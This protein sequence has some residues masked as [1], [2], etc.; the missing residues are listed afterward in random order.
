MAHLVRKNPDPFARLVTAGVMVWLIGQA[1][2]NIAVVL[3]LLPV[4]GIPLPFMS[5]GGSALLSSLAAVGIVIALN[6][7]GAVS[8]TE[9]FSRLHG[10]RR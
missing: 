10:N 8:V 9:H 4:L 7:S 1:L 5:V 6:R 2:I 3:E